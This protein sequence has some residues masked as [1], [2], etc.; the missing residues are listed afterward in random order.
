[1]SQPI[2]QGCNYGRDVDA[3]RCVA[4][5]GL[6]LGNTRSMEVEENPSSLFE[7]YETSTYQA[8]RVSAG[9][10]IRRNVVGL[11]VRLGSDLR[12]LHG[13]VSPR[14]Q[15]V[16]SEARTM[17]WGFGGGLRRNLFQLGANWAA[18]SLVTAQNPRPR[19]KSTPKARITVGGYNKTYDL[20]LRGNRINYEGAVK[21][22]AQARDATIEATKLREVAAVGSAVDHNNAR[23]MEQGL[24]L[25]Y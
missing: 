19:R 11:E 15:V 20:N 17:D 25:R 4:N 10:E 1:M 12:R 14:S 24:T 8:E 21:A 23:D 7:D 3:S 16:G 18:T 5:N 2:G 9:G 6:I 13:A 22:A